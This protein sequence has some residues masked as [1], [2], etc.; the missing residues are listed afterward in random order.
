MD[1][2]GL[3]QGGIIVALTVGLSQLAKQFIPAK[4]YSL[5]PVVLGVVLALLIDELSVSTGI[6]G[7]VL[8]LTS[9][10]LYDQKNLVK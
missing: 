2:F 9:A 10:G 3:T 4:F 7:L 5:L 6:K 1:T 8:G